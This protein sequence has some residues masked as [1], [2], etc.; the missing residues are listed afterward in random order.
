MRTRNWALLLLLVPFIALLWPP[1]FASLQPEWLGIPY[2]LWYQL[3][4]AVL[5]AVITGAVYLIQ[6]AGEAE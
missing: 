4:W 3:L 1:F 5:S 6:H 2:F